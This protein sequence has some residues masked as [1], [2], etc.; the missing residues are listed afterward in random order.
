ME[1]QGDFEEYMRLADEALYDAKSQGR[2]R[3][4]M[5]EQMLVTAVT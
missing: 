4:I 2:A 3:M 1:G 5:S